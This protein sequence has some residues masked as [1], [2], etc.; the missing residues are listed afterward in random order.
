MMPK[1]LKSMLPKLILLRCK[2]DSNTTMKISRKIEIKRVMFSFW[3]QD[4]SRD[5]SLELTS[6]NKPVE[7]MILMNLN[8]KCRMTCLYWSQTSMQSRKSKEQVEQ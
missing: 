7:V 4:K 6:K 3:I 1:N 2:V 8:K 5:T